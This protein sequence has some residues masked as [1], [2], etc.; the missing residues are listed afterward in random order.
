VQAD[1]LVARSEGGS[2]AREPAIYSCPEP[3]VL[4]TESEKKKQAW[5]GS[6]G[7]RVIHA[8]ACDCCGLRE[9]RGDDAAAQYGGAR[10]S[11]GA[12]ARRRP[13]PDRWR[14]SRSRLPKCA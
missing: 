10:R 9:D 12:R 3:P 4:C 1:A 14:G 6:V 2:A 13:G 7:E 5:K 11:S 8:T